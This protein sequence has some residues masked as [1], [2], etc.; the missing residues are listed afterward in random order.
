MRSGTGSRRL[1]NTSTG[2]G[3]RFEQLDC[4]VERRRAQVQVALRRRQVLM[5]RQP[6]ESP[7]AVSPRKRSIG[8]SPSRTSMPKL[9]LQ[10]CTE[11]KRLHKEMG[12]EMQVTIATARGT[13][14]AH[15]AADLI[16]DAGQELWIRL[17]PDRLHTFDAGGARLP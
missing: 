4:C 9:R 10:T 3:S 1:Q 17:P 12:N 5:S 6:P 16:V 15:A 2:F 11:L 13:E 14:V 8:R 7:V